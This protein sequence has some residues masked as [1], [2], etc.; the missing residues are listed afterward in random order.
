MATG[1]LR[2]I[3]YVALVRFLTVVNALMDRQVAGRSK[4]FKAHVTL[5]RLVSGMPGYVG[6]RGT[7]FGERRPAKI[8]FERLR[9][10][11]NSL[12]AIQITGR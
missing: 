2:L 8:S 4:A 7:S 1:L 9:A 3:A 10:V 6:L 11:V 12:V 5:I